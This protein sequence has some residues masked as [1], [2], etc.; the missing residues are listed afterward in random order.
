MS[1]PEIDP[2]QNRYEF[3]LYFDVKDGNPNGDP[4]AGAM[5]RQDPETMHGLVSDVALKRKIRNFVGENCGEDDGFSIYQSQGTVLNEA[6]ARAYEALGEKPKPAKLPEK[7]DKAAAITRWMCDTFFDIRAFGAVM[8]NEVNAGSVR[9]P[10]QINFARSVEP[11]MPINIGIT[12]GTVTNEKDREKQRTMGSKFI[13]PYGLYRV[14]GYINAN[15]A[16]KSG[17]DDDDLQLLWVAIRDMFDF[18]RA[19]TRGEMAAR[20]LIVFKHQSA[21]GNAQAHK[22]FDRVTTQRRSGEDLI[23][24][25]DPRLDNQPPARAFKDYDIDVDLDDLPKGI[26]VFEPF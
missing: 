13:I 10:V 1:K 14:H 6:H 5:P 26:E 25:G 7:A 9:G 17:F 4:D 11:V 19:A 12:R 24:V 3:V 21:L 16:K 15:C 8:T 18:D 20:R 23:E 2:I 22:L